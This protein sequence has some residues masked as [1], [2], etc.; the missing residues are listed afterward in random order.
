MGNKH[1][2]V[3]ILPFSAAPPWMQHDIEPQTSS[4]FW[5]VLVHKSASVPASSPFTFSLFILSLWPSWIYSAHL[6]P[7]LL[8]SSQGASDSSSLHSSFTNFKYKTK[9][10]M[11]PG[12]L[13]N[14]L[15][16][17][18]PPL[19]SEAKSIFFG[20]R[21][22]VIH[23]MR[24]FPAPALYNFSQKSLLSSATIVVPQ[25]WQQHYAA[26]VFQVGACP[27][28]PVL[29]VQ[30]CS[31]RGQWGRAAA[32]SRVYK[33]ILG[34]AGWASAATHLEKPSYHCGPH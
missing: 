2:G 28:L 26:D 4:N 17:I 18:N 6:L 27:W 33:G 13:Q 25:P 19:N 21:Q 14:K 24:F 1:D 3:V 8:S 15:I 5:L 29:S 10:T 16:T 11:S 22:P 9:K 12:P 34:R 23:R 31:V 20:K 32:C 7:F 30:A